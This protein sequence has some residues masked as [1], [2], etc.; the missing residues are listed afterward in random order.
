MSPNLEQI[1]ELK[2]HTD[3]VWSVAWSPTGDV[4]ASC[5]GDKT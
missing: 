4:L 5:G 2:G 1:A 3:R